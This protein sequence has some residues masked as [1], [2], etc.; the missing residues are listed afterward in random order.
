MTYVVELWRY[1]GMDD[2][3]GYCAYKDDCPTKLDFVE[4]IER[5]YGEFI[6]L[7]DVDTDFAVKLG[8]LHCF[9]GHKTPKSREMWVT[10]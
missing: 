4:A 5:E 6:S 10:R 1:P 9:T 7:L 3:E 2:A 8:D